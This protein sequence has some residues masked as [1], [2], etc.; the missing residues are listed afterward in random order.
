MLEELSPEE[1]CAYW[2]PKIYGIEPGKG[3]KGYRKACLELLNYVTGYSKATCS[4]WI[5]YPDERKP[6]RILYRYLRLVHLEWLREEISPN[7]L[8]NFLDSLDKLN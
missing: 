6:P 8:K 5:D 7:T 2:V 4:N 3:K 1:F